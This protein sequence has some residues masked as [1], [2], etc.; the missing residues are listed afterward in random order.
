MRVN[1]KQGCI[2][3]PWLFNVYVDAVMKGENGD[4]EYGHEIPRG[5]EIVEITWPLVCRRIGFMWQ[6]VRRPESDGGTFC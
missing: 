5:E 6:V 3:L 1:V 2:M 4:G